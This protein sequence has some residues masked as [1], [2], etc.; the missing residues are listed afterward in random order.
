ML[1]REDFASERY[2]LS[3]H[4]LS[5]LANSRG[6]A[7]VVRLVLQD[8]AIRCTS[9]RVRSRSE[10]GANVIRRVR[11]YLEEQFEVAE[12]IP[13]GFLT[14]PYYSGVRWRETANVRLHVA[15]PSRVKT[16]NRGVVESESRTAGFRCRLSIE[17]CELWRVR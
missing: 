1:T 4:R 14:P 15:Q 17:S 3:K 16:S 8:E 6:I 10:V 7:F 12:L 5:S 13:G 9:L 11:F 2:V